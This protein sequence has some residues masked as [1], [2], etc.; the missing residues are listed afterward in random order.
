MN[1][2]DKDYLSNVM[3]VVDSIYQ[4]IND[5]TVIYL[6]GGHFSHNF[7]ADDFAI[8]TLNDAIALGSMIIKNIKETLSSL[9]AF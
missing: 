9:M 8:N 4:Q 6:E 7:G 1:L 2:Y 5:K 3:T